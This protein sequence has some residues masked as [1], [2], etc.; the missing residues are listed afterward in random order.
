MVESSTIT[1]K[2]I[3]SF[4]NIND[5]IKNEQNINNIIGDISRNRIHRLKKIILD[6]HRSLY[7]IKFNFELKNSS[8]IINNIIK[9][10]KQKLKNIKINGDNKIFKNYC[11][12]LIVYN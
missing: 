10:F 4:F 3:K 7:Q 1:T 11:I 9:E 5:K 8:D 2:L 6:F 12:K